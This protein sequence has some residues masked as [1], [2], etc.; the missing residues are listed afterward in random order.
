MAVDPVRRLEII[1][2]VRVTKARYFRYI[3][4]KAWDSSRAS[5]S[6]TCTST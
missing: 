2:A 5:S 4:Q 1:E 3:D 6:R